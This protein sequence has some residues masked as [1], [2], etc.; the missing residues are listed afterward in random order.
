M[1]KLLGIDISHWQKGIEIKN[2]EADF[3]IVK[4]T[5]GTSKKDE[6]LDSFASAIQST[7]RLFGVYHFADG[8]SSGSKEAEWF[9]KN[10]KQY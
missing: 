8:K 7:N 9:V 6:C 2:V 10:I 4:A 1:G 3:I 5:Q